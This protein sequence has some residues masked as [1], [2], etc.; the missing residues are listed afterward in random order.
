MIQKYIKSEISPIVA[1]QITLETDGIHY[2]KWGHKNHGKA[3]D[4]LVNNGGDC[5]TVD[6]ESFAATYEP[7]ADQ[8]GLYIKTA[9][10][11]AEPATEAGTVGTKENATDYGIGDYLV[12]N[13]EDGTDSYAVEKAEFES[14]YVEV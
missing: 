14:M 13:N 4:W 2:E 10:V 12:S 1:V 7:V 3:G 5:Y 6:Q 9:P 11:W 8:M